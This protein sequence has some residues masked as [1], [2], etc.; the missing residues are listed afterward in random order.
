MPGQCLSS[1]NSDTERL[2]QLR[3]PEVAK[4]MYSK[5]QF[6]YLT[7]EQQST[8]TEKR[9]V[10]TKLCKEFM[11]G[12]ELLTHKFEKMVPNKRNIKRGSME[13]MSFLDSNTQAV[14]ITN[15]AVN[16]IRGLNNSRKGLI[17]P[18]LFL[19]DLWMRE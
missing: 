19:Y 3:Q 4:R 14:V 2:K 1:R 17:F 15:N 18:V 12:A 8:D 7:F 9:I 16:G 13:H 5:L 6:G 10:L 11:S